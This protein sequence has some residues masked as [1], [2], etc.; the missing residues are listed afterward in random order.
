MY[1]AQ[2]AALFGPQRYGI[3]EATPK[4]GK[5]LGCIIW[6]IERALQ[7]TRG[8]EFW[9]AAPVS[10]QTRIAFNRVKLMLEPR[11]SYTVNESLL[12]ITLHPMET[13]LAFKSCDRP[14]SLYGE[15]VY[16][17]VV[18]EATRVKED[19]WNALRT[20]ITKT[21][22]PARIIGNVRGRKNWAYKMARRAEAGDP[23]MHY[24]KL[25]ALDAIAAGLWPESELEDAKSQLPE[26]VFRELYF[27]EPS[28]DGGNP[29]GLDHI[30]ACLVIDPRTSRPVGSD[31]VSMK[32]P[33]VWGWD[34]A[35]GIGSAGGDWVWGVGLDEEGAICRSERW[36]SAWTDT[37]PRILSLT[38]ST[39]A[40]VDS[41]GAGDP[42][43]ELLARQAPNIQGF[44]FTSTSKQQLMEG[45]AVAIQ[46][47][48][49]HFGDHLLA[50]E[51]RAFEF[52]VVTS[53]GRVTGVKYSAPEGLHDDGVCA[54]ALA[55]QGQ[56]SG[57]LAQGM[58]EYVREQIAAQ[59][60]E[61]KPLFGGTRRVVRT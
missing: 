3:V 48:Q 49:I 25:T 42:I 35:K 37:M 2:E 8:Q 21:R 28:E 32:P 58:Y 11:D 43:V 60:D 16:G 59:P 22:A 33:Q 6:Q 7:G 23:D 39:P 40:L 54:L 1:P 18:D 24:A 17:L 26:R 29:F 36:Q 14:D 30:T 57:F 53:N 34:L 51:L 15:D 19:A 9:W 52:L 47:H 41:T 13:V 61:R 31:V 56:R 5:T 46:R 45:L 12:R 38:G 50:Q 44:H 10:D 4:S 55:V 20:T 27:A